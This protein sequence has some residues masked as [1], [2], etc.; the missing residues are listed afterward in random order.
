MMIGCAK[1]VL[2]ISL[3]GFLMVG[4]TPSCH[5]SKDRYKLIAVDNVQYLFERFVADQ[6]IANDSIFLEKGNIFEEFRGN[7]LIIKNLSKCTELVLKNESKILSDSS[8][9]FC[10]DTL[11]VRKKLFVIDKRK[12]H[13]FF[14]TK[15][16][17]NCID[18]AAKT[19][20]IYNLELTA[21]DLEKISAYKAENIGREFIITRNEEF[22]SGSSN[23]KSTKSG[24]QIVGN[25]N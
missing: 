3:L 23:I 9:K 1:K 10:W 25:L 18:S 8:L 24:F 2:L 11:N 14:P 16:K 19:V 21:I 15:S 20:C 12:G 4:L 6:N 5:K 22:F 13:L 7:V 17:T